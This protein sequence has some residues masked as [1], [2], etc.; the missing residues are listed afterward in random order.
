MAK[1]RYTGRLYRDGKTKLVPGEIY[2]LSAK[3]AEGL[4]FELVPEVKEPKKVKESTQE[5]ENG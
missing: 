3:E 5:A 4:P 1:Y 2:E